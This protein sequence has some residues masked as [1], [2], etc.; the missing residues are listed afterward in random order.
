M[1]T[2][3]WAVDQPH[4]AAKEIKPRHPS[5]G[6]TASLDLRTEIR[7]GM[8]LPTLDIFP[9]ADTGKDSRSWRTVS[10]NNKEEARS[11]SDEARS[12]ADTPPYIQSQFWL[13]G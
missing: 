7:S 2:D 6:H 10:Y 3:P 5:P 13:S 4:A 12:K 11:V 8:R 1:K 9:A